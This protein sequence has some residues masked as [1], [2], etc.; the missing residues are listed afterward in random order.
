MTYST[1]WVLSDGVVSTKMEI[2]TI[3]VKRK[4]GKGRG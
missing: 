3:D 2:L 4:L 1:Q